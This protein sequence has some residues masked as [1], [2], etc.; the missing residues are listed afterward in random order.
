MTK[1]RLL[2]LLSIAALA[3][4][5]ALVAFTSTPPWIVITAL[6]FFSGLLL[7]LLLGSARSSF[8]D[9]RGQANQEKDSL[10][11]SHQLLDATINEMREGLLVIDHEMRVLASNKAA[12]NLLSNADDRIEARR[13]TELTRNPAI[14]DAFLDALHGK[15]RAGVKVET[16]QHGRRVFDLR[17]APLRSANGK[18]TQGAVGVFFDITRLERLE[19]IRQEFLSNVSHELR[20]PL[21]SIIAL[22]ETLE[23]GAINDSQHNRRFLSIIQKNAARMHRL[24]DDILELSAIE[25]GNVKVEPEVIRLRYLVEDVFGTLAASASAKTSSGALSISRLANSSAKALVFLRSQAKPNTRS[26]SP[27]TPSPPP[28]SR[29]VNGIR[30]KRPNSCPAAAGAELSSR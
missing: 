28:G 20:T 19:V 6:A 17:V 14:Y 15:E 2:A 4:L 26:G 30:R 13:L 23:T 22:A 12:R 10:D 3:S 21:T 27:S 8:A 16:Y 1:F 24:I 7:S 29:N 5:T 11:T 18:G 25:A 9:V